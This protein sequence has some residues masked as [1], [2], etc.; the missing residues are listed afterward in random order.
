MTNL[1][2]DAPLRSRGERGSVGAA[3]LLSAVQPILAAIE[4]ATARQE[5]RSP[6]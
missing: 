2:P 4:H 5:A 6:S 1:G 3:F